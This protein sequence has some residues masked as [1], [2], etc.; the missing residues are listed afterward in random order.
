MDSWSLPLWPSPGRALGLRLP[1][2]RVS[3]FQAARRPKKGARADSTQRTSVLCAADCILER[4]LDGRPHSSLQK[5]QRVRGR[6]HR[7]GD[8]CP[9]APSWL[10]VTTRVCPGRPLTALSGHLQAH[11]LPAS[12]GH[13]VLLLLS[14]CPPA[15]PACCPGCLLAPSSGLLK[16]H[17]LSESHLHPPSCP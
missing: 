10:C 8:I 15:H 14:T 1:G 9:Y 2:P 4:G 16:C 17:L 13:C 5:E 12:Q 7:Q 6:S 3:L 11:I